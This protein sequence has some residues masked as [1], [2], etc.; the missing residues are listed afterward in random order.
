MNGRSVGWLLAACLLAGLGNTAQ[1][2]DTISDQVGATAGQFRV[3]ESG[4]A[5]YS[6]PILAVPGTAGVTPQVA[7]SYSSQGG[8]GPVGRGWSISGLSAIARCRA[9]REAGDFIVS[10]VPQDGTPPAVEFN[11]NDRFCLDG[12]RLI[13]APAGSPAC[14]AVSGFTA[15]N[16]RTQS[17]SFQR[18]CA[19]VPAAASANGPA[20]F[21]VE[22]QDGSTSFY[23]DRDDWTA[24]ATRPDGYVNSTAI[25]H[26]AKALSWWQ[27]RFQD[28]TGNY[29]DYRYTANPGGASYPGESV[30]ASIEYTGKKQ[31]SGQ[32]GGNWSPY[33]KVQF[34]YAARP[35]AEFAR[36]AVSHGAIWQTRYLASITSVG[37][38]ATNQQARH[39]ALNYATSASGSG[40]RTLTSIT[41]CRDSTMAVCLPPTT[42]AWS[43]AVN[44]FSSA[45]M[46]TTAGFDGLVNLRLGDVDGDGLTDVVWFKPASGRLCNSFELFVSFG[47]LNASGQLT[48]NRV[49]QTSWCF[50]RSIGAA[51]LNNAW[52]LLDYDGD[53]RDDLFV[54]GAGANWSLYP[55]LGRPTSGG[56]VFSSSNILAANP[57]QGIGEV[58]VPITNQ[59]TFLA[60][61][62]GDGLLDVMYRQ[63]AAQNAVFR[64]RLMERSGSAFFW[65]GERELVVQ[66]FSIDSRTYEGLLNPQERMQMHDFDGDSRSDLVLRVTT[67]IPTGNC[68]PESTSLIGEHTDRSGQVW[69]LHNAVAGGDTDAGDQMTGLLCFTNDTDAGAYGVVDI[70]PTQI[71]LR[72]REKWPISRE[73][74][75][76]G[77]TIPIL[78]VINRDFHF[79]DFNGDGLTDAL[80]K[81]TGSG[82]MVDL[83]GLNVTHTVAASFPNEDYLQLA[84]VNGD[85]RTDILFP[86]EA[87]NNYR[88][89]HGYI[90][91]TDGT[92]PATP[93]LVPGGNAR[94]CKNAS[95][96]L[97]NTWF[98][99]SDFDG[100]AATD[101]VAIYDNSADH[102]SSRAP[103]AS[104]YQPR[105]T[106]ATITDGHGATTQ[107]TYRPLTLADAYR[108]ESGARALNW[109]RGS[110]VQELFGPQY[111]VVRAQSSAP[112]YGNAAAMSAVHYRYA[113]AR[114]QAG[115]GGM[116]G[117]RQ[118]QSFD[119]TPTGSHIVTTTTYRQD[120]PYAGL[121]LETTRRVV[122]GSHTL[123][124]CLTGTVTTSCFQPPG[125]A[126]PAIG[127]TLVAHS[128]SSWET[129]PTFAP[130]VQAPVHVRLA[131]SDERVHALNNGALTS[132]VLTSIVY[133]NY[134]F[135]A[136]TSVDTY[137]SANTLVSRVQTSN[138]YT[139]LTSPWRL[140]RLTVSTVTHTRGSNSTSRS[141]SYTYDTAGAA[142]GQLLSERIQPGGAADQDL[143]TF[144]ALDAFG[145][146]THTYTCSNHLTEA[147]CKSTAVTFQSTTAARI[148]RYARTT[149]D[150]RGRFATATY[151]PYWNGSGTTEQL[152]G[153]IL[154]RNLFGDVTHARDGRGVDTLATYGHLGRPWYTWTE[155]VNTASPGTPAAGVESWTTWR[156]CGTGGNQVTCPAGAML[157]QQV[158]TEGAPTQWSYHDVLGR[159]VLAVSQTRH[160]GTAN[161]G[162]SGVCTAYDAASRPL[163]VSEPFFLTSTAAATEPGAFASN[164]CTTARQWNLTTYDALGRVTA[165]Q[166]ADSTGITTTYS[167]LT[168]TTWDANG[169]ATSR[170]VNALGEVTTST[171]AVGLALSFTYTP[172]GNIATVS[173]NAGRGAVTTTFGYDTLGRKTSHGDLDSG[174]TT[175]QYNALGETTQQL[176]AANHRIETLL[177]ARGRPWRQRAYHWSG[178]AHGLQSTTTFVYDTLVPG[179]LTSQSIAPGTEGQTHHHYYDTLGRPSVRTSAM[180]ALNFRE[181]TQYDSLG[182][183]W[184]TQDASGFWL[185]QEFDARGFPTKVCESSSTD[186]SPTC[187]GSSFYASIEQVDAR[188][189]VTLERRGAS[190]GPTIAR[191]YNALNGNLVGLC[192]GPS[193]IVQNALYEYDN[194]GQVTRREQAGRYAERFQYDNADRL[195]LGWFESIGSTWYGTTAPWVDPDAAAPANLSFHTQYDKLG[196]VCLRRMD[197][198]FVRFNYPGRAGCGLEGTQGSGSTSAGASAHQPTHLSVP[199]VVTI[200]NSHDARGN[201]TTNGD[202]RHYEYNVLNQATAIWRNDWANPTVRSRFAYGPDGQ[203]YRRIDDGSTLSGT[204][205]T[206][207]V[208]SVERLQLPG[209]AIRWRR[210]IGNTAIVEYTSEGVSEGFARALG[211]G[212]VRHQF[213][214]PQGTPQVIGLLSGASVTILERLDTAPN[215]DWRTPS[216]PFG[217]N[218][219]AHTTRGFTGHEALAGLGT[220]HMNGRL[221]WTGGMRMF[222]PDPIVTQPLNPQNWNPYSY[223]VNN[224]LNLTDPSGY[225]FLG[226]MFGA[227]KGLLRSVMQGLGPNV[228]GIAIGVGCSF[229][230]PWAALC[231][232][233]ASYDAARAF[234]ASSSDARRAGVAG[235]FTALVSWGVSEYGSSLSTY[236]RV[237]I[238]ATAGGVASVIQGGKFGHGF[239]SAG[240][241]AGVSPHIGRIQNDVLGTVA[242]AILGGTVSEMTGGKFANGAVSGAFSYAMSAAAENLSR[243]E[244]QAFDPREGDTA[245]GRHGLFPEYAGDPVYEAVYELGVVGNR[246]SANGRE[247]H[248]FG[249]VDA[250]GNLVF[251]PLRSGREANI[252]TRLLTE[253]AVAFNSAHPGGT[254]LYSFH[255]H[256]SD[257][258][259]PGAFENF[260]PTDRAFYRRNPIVG[261]VTG[262]VSTPRGLLLMHNTTTG[263]TV[264]IG[265]VPAVPHRPGR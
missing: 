235:A 97:A 29:I 26:T 108:R 146:R 56:R 257:V 253:M 226:D 37:D 212:T 96:N 3:D 82:W 128:I 191:S 133:G 198:L 137:N 262:F 181:Q 205:I 40:A 81:N 74:A 88:P 105:D 99:F 138:T 75:V 215:G 220:T 153:Q 182:R 72:Q 214:D 121:P 246:R 23:G 177:D 52:H 31:L 165:I 60:D 201:M 111:V 118:I 67:H 21:S 265:R 131:G 250:D 20:F 145:N 55:S 151:S 167:G 199:G 68:S 230:G 159:V 186:S 243:G 91:R 183:P 168:T 112:V 184:K 156:R 123:P 61:M 244:H 227:F 114:V 255:T 98:L 196:N 93:S 233:G 149:Y 264:Q 216:P 53:G 22:R 252:T 202:V 142:T 259:R 11:A 229:A 32:S 7:L 161:K 258:G 136:S 45:D 160:L 164:V 117:F 195:T 69:Y 213:S 194:K 157:R 193:C 80:M 170:V 251:Q 2:Q 224:P 147:A 104:R 222:Q 150:N 189:A 134:G 27:T 59:G 248:A 115:G 129:S 84:D 125:S 62:N 148:H 103:A 143:R 36:G 54:A 1:A 64:V 260:S 86:Q 95:C 218:G 46:V 77:S 47:E 166:R 13:P 124:A 76:V 16:L 39:Y 110:P 175:W 79:A 187:A 17:E 245:T 203:R 130:G 73:I 162:F 207:I 190:Y 234:G 210:S 219:S 122:S 232:G 15:S 89:F 132:K 101:F 242:S 192:T 9:T 10:G 197:G 5:T 4:A 66:E 30:V 127:G 237:A 107:L 241:T 231:A 155:T 42:F 200:H 19:Y 173:R 58:V 249:G 263:A 12:Q 109:G 120:A 238:S 140:G 8:D 221:Y 261:R 135:A 240:I 92:F 217:Q 102:Y 116:L 163:R 70:T 43:T 41:E 171:D 94:G 24:S 154:S 176:D 239:A 90:A 78:M 180:D 209:G 211:E 188:G 223:V 119:T 169:H 256:G 228:T 141:T 63:S 85:G 172:D 34:N 48:F 14:P 144:H 178:S 35:A 179:A 57:S 49:T 28:S 83:T 206:H 50:P 100:D 65:G 174:T 6:I 87:N 139:H 38:I 225:S 126:F 18:V 71:T 44:S 106:L 113:G 204:T 25:G 208:G 185:K 51:D 152:D 33:A 254:V 158:V 247:H 236:S